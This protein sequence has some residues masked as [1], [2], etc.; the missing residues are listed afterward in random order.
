VDDVKAL[1]DA[2]DSKIAVKAVGNIRDAQ[3]ALALIEA[4]A[5]RIGTTNPGVLLRS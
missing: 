4:G 3:A 5:T 2:L 1:R